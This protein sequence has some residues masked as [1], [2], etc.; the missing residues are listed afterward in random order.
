MAHRKSQA[1]L[2]FLTTY[3]WAFLVIII[4]ISALY[5]FGV[6]DFSKYLPQKCTFTSQFP[7]IDFSM[8]D[9]AAGEVDIRFKLLNDIGE[10]VSVEGLSITNDAANPLTCTLDTALPFDWS[11]DEEIDF[12]FSD[13]HDGVF[14]KGERIEA[15]INLTYYS[16]LT[17][18]GD[19]P[20]HQLR[21]KIIGIVG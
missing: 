21:G 9:L 13:C 5:Y 17:N 1:A 2:E 16:P 4:T 6:F 10:T 12:E 19:E 7:C 14:I 18:P 3:A 8:R 20:R 11:D 15:K